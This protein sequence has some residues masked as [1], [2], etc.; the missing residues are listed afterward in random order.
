VQLQR[1]ERL[2]LLQ[3]QLLQQAQPQQPVRLQ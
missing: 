1:Q 3:E 2:Q